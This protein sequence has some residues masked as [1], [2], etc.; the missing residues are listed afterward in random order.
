MTGIARNLSL[1][2][3]RHVP[4][5]PGAVFAAWTDPDELVRWWG[6][7][8]VEC[9][10]AEVDLRVGGAFRLGNRMPTGE[11]VW[12]S[13]E[14]E[15]IERPHRLVYTW[16]AGSG[17]AT[18]AD[19]E[20]VTVEF[21]ELDGGTEVTVTHRQIASEEARD[22]HHQGWLGCLDGLVSLFFDG[23]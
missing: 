11:V 8:G 23:R 17:G 10:G 4:A 12:I 19:A 21:A 7:P 6:P 1:V 16:V 14:Y 5:P 15:V 3:R 9:A 22:G 13:G 20:R 18:P 2:V